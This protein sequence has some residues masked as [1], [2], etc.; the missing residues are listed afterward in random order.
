MKI[1]FVPPRVY[2]CSDNSTFS[3]GRTK[4]YAYSVKKDVICLKHFVNDTKQECD[5]KINIDDSN[6]SY[7]S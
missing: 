7:D 5:N 3:F 4:T 2:F 6:K 1:I